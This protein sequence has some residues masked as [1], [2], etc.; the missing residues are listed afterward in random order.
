MVADDLTIHSTGFAAISI[1][2]FVGNKSLKMNT[3]KRNCDLAA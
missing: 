1:P 2:V 3:G